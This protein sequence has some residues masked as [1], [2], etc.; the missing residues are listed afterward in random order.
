MSTRF[1]VLELDNERGR[2]P[3][4]L[5]SELFRTARPYAQ[6]LA[7]GRGDGI[8]KRL[9]LAR[10]LEMTITQSGRVLHRGAQRGRAS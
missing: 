9:S 5:A 10:P 2:G 6:A 7:I 3:F 4:T 8:L 1:P